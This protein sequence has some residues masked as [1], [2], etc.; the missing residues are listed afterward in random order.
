MKASFPFAGRAVLS[1]SVMLLA[2]CSA[3]AAQGVTPPKL[4]AF[5][6][7]PATI[8][9]SAG[10]AT[11]TVNFS[12]TGAGQGVSYF[13]MALVD[14]SGV[15][16][17]HASRAFPPAPTI[18][19]SVS[20]GFPRFSASGSWQ[21][22]EVFL[23]DNAGNTQIMGTADLAA[24]GFP[25]ALTVSSS[26]DATPPNLTAFSF[27]PAA[28]D[29]T[30]GPA[31][32]AVNFSATDDLSGVSSF[33][34]DFVSPSGGSTQHSVVNLN[35][36]VSVTGSGTLTFPR[37]SEAG[38]WTVSVVY[39]GDAAG[40]TSILGPTILAQLGFATNLTVT[41][42]TDSTPPALTAFSFSPNAVN[43][44]SSSANVTVN[45]TATD[46]RSGVNLFQVSFVSRICDR[47][48]GDKRNRIG[49]RHHSTV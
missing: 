3:G 16:I 11:V 45:F 9:T 15:F 8:N 26:V 40:N 34:V 46:D 41:S 23:M 47:P 49:D 43:T 18:T 2:M 44:T 42:N 36:A 4:T 25:T 20:I 35:P 17:Q 1:S 48:S 10:P 31:N 12:I 14:P 39:V 7:T 24:A 33:E 30:A 38:T 28:I 19:S 6:L 13:E 21:V 27:A 5:S 29:T 37:F 22:A 32:V